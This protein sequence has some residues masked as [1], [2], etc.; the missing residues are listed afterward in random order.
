[1]KAN[2]NREVRSNLLPLYLK[3]NSVGRVHS[4][5]NNGLNIQL[6]DFLIYISSADTSLS[7]F[8]LNIDRGKLGEILDAA[9]IGDIVVNKDDKLTL[10][11]TPQIITINYKVIE[12]LNLKLPQIKCGIGEISNTKLYN[13]LKGIKFKESIGLD[14]DETTVK[15]INLLVDGDKGDLGI[16]SGII[17][18]F[19]GRGRGLTPS[20][21]DIIIGFTLALMIFG[22]FHNWTR[23]LKLELLEN[24]TTIISKMYLKALLSGYVSEDFNQLARLMDSSDT[25]FIEKTIKRVQSFGHT[26]G[27]DTLFGFYLGL[28]FLIKQ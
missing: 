21:D 24:R 28:R 13:C 8:G 9:K 4:K 17:K 12:E 5:F 3:S 1:M 11:C 14:L 20:G 19:S 2:I 25:D 26:S 23:A 22:N 16:N 6:G 18:F 10:Y 15:N 7:A 27:N